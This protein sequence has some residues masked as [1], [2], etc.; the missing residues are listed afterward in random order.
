M[1]L[2]SRAANN[3]L[4]VFFSVKDVLHLLSGGDTNSDGLRPDG[5]KKTHRDA[6]TIKRGGR[7]IAKRR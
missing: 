4:D 6:T 2:V 1:T 7:R 5:C 3:D